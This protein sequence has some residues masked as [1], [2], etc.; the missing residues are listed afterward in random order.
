M[1]S[2]V[3]AVVAVVALLAGAVLLRRVRGYRVART[4]GGAPEASID[5]ALRW[6]LEGRDRYVRVHGRI[7]SDEEFPD[8]QDRPLVYRARRLEVADRPGRWRILDEERVAV[9]FALQDRGSA[10]ALDVDALGDGLVVLA[11]EATGAAR[12]VPDRVPPDVA[13]DALVR[14]RIE[15]VSAVEHATAAGVP[16]VGSDGTPFLTEGLGRPLILTTLEVADAMRVLSAGQRREVIVAAALL[17][18]GLAA[19]A[20]ALATWLLG[21]LAGA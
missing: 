11:R 14:H 6:A 20:L 8:E 4:L 2:V 7:T 9:P 18:G 21:M 19:A 16:R 13:P 17:A 15:Q 5:D 12:E 10:I 3:L 1:T